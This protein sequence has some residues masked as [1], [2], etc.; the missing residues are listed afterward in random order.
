M[1]ILAE[2]QDLVQKKTKLVTKRMC[3]NRD[4]PILTYENVETFDN[5]T[6]E[7]LNDFR[8][9]DQIVMT[10]HGQGFP[11]ELPC[12]LDTFRLA[13]RKEMNID[14][15]QYLPKRGFNDFAKK[16]ITNGDD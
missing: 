7:E 2:V 5:L 1:R 12:T 15:T 10:I 13:V 11:I 6:E 9:L 8:L 4:L 16:Y 14:Y 3:Y